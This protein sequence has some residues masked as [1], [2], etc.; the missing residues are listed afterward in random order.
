MLYIPGMIWF[1]VAGVV[2]QRRTIIELVRSSRLYMI[3]G[4]ALSCALLLPLIYSC[5]QDAHTLYSIV[6]LPNNHQWDV[7]QIA[8]NFLR[9]PW[10]LVWHGP[11]DPAMWLGHMP[12]MD[13]GCVLFA[14]LGIYSYAVDWQLDRSRM[15]LGGLALSW[16][17][18]SL[19]GP[20]GIAVL[21]PFCFLLVAA[22]IA[23]MVRQWFE[24]FPRNPFARGLAYI[25]LSGATLA[26]GWYNV[27]H[28]FIAWPQV[29]VTRES[30]R[31]SL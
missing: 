31:Q 27:Q 23:F 16:G 25:L 29:P 14:V 10:Q 15:V 19:G 20:V 22:G 21:L 12:L 8:R 4:S 30:F 1:V 26:I 6:G 3:V 2:W 17:L 7:L 9:V 18:V 5:I 11:N 28:Y 24:V 13:F